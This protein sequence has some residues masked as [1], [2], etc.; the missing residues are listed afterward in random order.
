MANVSASIE[1]VNTVSANVLNGYMK[2]ANAMKMASIGIGVMAL[3]MAAKM[4]A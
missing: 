1:A 2:I 4:S 3:E